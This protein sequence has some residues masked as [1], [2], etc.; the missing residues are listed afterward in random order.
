[1]IHLMSGVGIKSED[2]ER[3]SPSSTVV[4]PTENQG[5]TVER[6]GSYISK[7]F[8]DSG[9]FYGIVRGYK[10]PFYQ[11]SFFKAIIFT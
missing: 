7:T 2:D 3:S 4:S 9:V 1:M 5:E 10:S 8:D 6:V 11:V